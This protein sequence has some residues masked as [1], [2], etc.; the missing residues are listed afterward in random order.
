M[1][2]ILNL[3]AVIY[4]DDMISQS[5]VITNL[6]QPNLDFPNAYTN[7]QRPKNILK[8]YAVGYTK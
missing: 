6:D 7:G 4:P 2:N 1:R 5:Q 3:F 8:W